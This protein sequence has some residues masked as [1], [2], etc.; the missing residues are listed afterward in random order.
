MEAVKALQDLRS[1]LMV[2]DNVRIHDLLEYDEK[3]EQETK[4]KI[5]QF[6]KE[7]AERQGSVYNYMGILE[8]AK[9]YLD[10]EI[11][12]IEQFKDQFG[13]RVENLYANPL[14]NSWLTNYPC[15]WNTLNSLNEIMLNDK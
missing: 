4:N 7:F 9:F 10:E 13:Y 12:S 8:L 5:E 1:M 15:Y 11:I 14:I 2:G 6:R 3:N